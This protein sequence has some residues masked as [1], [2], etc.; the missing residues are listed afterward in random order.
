MGPMALGP[1]PAGGPVAQDQLVVW[2]PSAPLPLSKDVRVQ[3]DMRGLRRVTDED[4]DRQPVA[5][6]A[7]PG[8]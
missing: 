4:P 8:K 1:G 6:S 7:D 5:V 3:K 2:W